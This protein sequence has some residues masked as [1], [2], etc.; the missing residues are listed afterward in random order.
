MGPASATYEWPA[1]RNTMG[2]KR[3]PLSSKLSFMW[4]SQSFCIKIPSGINL[5]FFNYLSSHAN[6]PVRIAQMN[7]EW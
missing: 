1:S 4:E 2:E 5:F 3:D 6:S 7:H